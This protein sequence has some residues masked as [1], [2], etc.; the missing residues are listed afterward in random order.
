MKNIVVK[1]IT[2]VIFGGFS[3]RFWSLR[4][5]MNLVDLTNQTEKREHQLAMIPFYAWECITIQQKDLDI[6]LVIKD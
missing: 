3:S 5:Q 1:N 4:K 2:G 6:D